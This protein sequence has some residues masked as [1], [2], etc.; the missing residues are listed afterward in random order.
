MRFKN[1]TAIVTGSSSGIGKAVALKLGTQG[2]NVCI[3]FSQ[4]KNLEKAKT[5]ALQIEKAGGKAIYVQADIG[6]VSEVKKMFDET[7]KHFNKLDI[8]VNNAAY[9]FLK[10]ISEVTEEEY[11]YIFNINVKGLFFA[12]QFAAKTMNEG[13]KIINISS[14]TTGLMLSG[15]GV[16]DATKGAVEIFS[17]ILSKEM[18]P[19]NISVNV[20]SP[21]AT[22]TEQF[23]RGKTDEFIAQ[24]SAMSHFNRI[25]KTDEIAKVVSFF[26]SDD[27]SWVTGQN[28]RV[29]GGTC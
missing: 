17:R 8:L 20:I 29:N 11:D 12:C 21:G 24:L 14:A 26:C 27:S 3:N 18:G 2:A 10:P 16:Y 4:D 5:I 13:G 6:K 23:R 1:K 22:E 25:A 9:A 28:I 15:Y 19:K 7:L